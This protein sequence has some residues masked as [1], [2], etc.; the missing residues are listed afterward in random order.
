MSRKTKAAY[1]HL[2]KYIQA[3]VFQMEPYSVI[4]DFEKA[5]R[6]ALKEVYPNTTYYTC[7]F[8]YM[9]CIRRKCAKMKN[10]FT[11]INANKDAYRLYQKFLVLPL[12]HPKEI[13]TAYIFLKANAKKYG[14]LFKNFLKYFEKQ[15]FK[16]VKF[17]NKF[18]KV[19]IKELLNFYMSKATRK[20]E[21]CILR[22]F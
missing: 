11:G 13:I 14:D 19:I 21:I 17:A 15:W 1:I 6:N 16:Q 5:L 10:F 4:T 18:K 20:T 2:F 7:W 3:N 9:Q 8:H 22:S 12:L